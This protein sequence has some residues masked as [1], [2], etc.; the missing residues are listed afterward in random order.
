MYTSLYLYPFDEKVWGKIGTFY[1]WWCFLGKIVPTIRWLDLKIH[2]NPLENPEIFEK[3]NF[4]L[5]AQDYDGNIVRENK[6]D[7]IQ[8]SCQD[9]EDLT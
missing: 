1:L 7:H 5:E 9:S 3:M 2:D 8:Q 4:Q 6:S